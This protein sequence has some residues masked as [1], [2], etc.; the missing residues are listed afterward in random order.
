MTVPDKIVPD[1]IC[2]LKT[3]QA[4]IAEQHAIYTND[5]SAQINVLYSIAHSFQVLTN[6][7][8]HYIHGPML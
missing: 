5:K 1:K 4:Q 7:L 2:K 8:S 6:I 3:N